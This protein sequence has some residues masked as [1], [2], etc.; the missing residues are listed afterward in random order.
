M[1]FL[2]FT[3]LFTYFNCNSILSEQDDLIL[4]V[5][6]SNPSINHSFKKISNKILRVYEKN[7]HIK[8]VLADPGSSYNTNDVVYKK[9]PIGMLLFS[10][11]EENKNGFILFETRGISSQCNFVYYKMKQRKVAEMKMV[12]LKK[13]PKDCSELKTLVQEGSYFR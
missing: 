4:H 3:L 5:I 10:G 9:E 13:Q 8:L 6:N 1:N 7:Y 12:I 11:H 2:F